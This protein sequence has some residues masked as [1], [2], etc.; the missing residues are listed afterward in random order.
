MIL[1]DDSVLNFKKW[2]FMNNIYRSNIVNTNF[3]A[4]KRISTPNKDIMITKKKV[5]KTN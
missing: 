2:I 3:L 5:L 1:Y 4:G